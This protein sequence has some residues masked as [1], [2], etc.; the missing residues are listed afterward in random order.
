M[1]R[2]ARI[3]IRFLLVWALEALSL[4]VMTRIVP[5]IGWLTRDA[6]SAFANALTAALILALVNTLVRPLLLR[7]KLPITWLTSNGSTLVVNVLLLILIG[8]LLPLLD[9]ESLT[10][11]FLGGLVLSI[12]NGVLTGF[13]NI[14]RDDSFFQNVVEHIAKRQ[15][16][17]GVSEPGRGIVMLEIDGLSCR[18]LQA[19]VE[20]G[21]MP[22]VR[23]MLRTTHA[24]SGYD[25]G[26]PSQTSSSQAGILYGDNF[27]IPAFRWYDKERGKLMVSN[28]FDDAAEI[29]ARYAHGQGLLRGGSSINNLIAGDAEKSLLTLSTL[30]TANEQE[31]SRRAQDLYVFWLNPYLFTRSLVLS[32]GEVLLELGQAL[33]QRLRDVQPRINRLE[34]GY[35]F[36][37]ALT[38]VFLRDIST[39]LVALDVVRGV[40]AIY[41]TYLGYDVVAHHAGPDTSDALNTLRSLDRQVRRIRNVIAA[42]APR[43]YDLFV[44]SDHGQSLGATFRQ[45]YGQS[46]TELI[47]AHTASPVSVAEATGQMIG[48]SY[49]AA[50]VAEL[51]SAEQAVAGRMR[52]SAMRGSRRVLQQRIKN[53][54][55]AVMGAPVVVCA[56]GNLANV[57]FNLHSGKVSLSEINTEHPQLVDEL[58]MQAGIGFV[59]VY[60]DESTPLVL[61]KAG[62]RDLVTGIVTGVDP[63]QPYAR[64]D[65]RAQQLWRVAQFPHAGDLIIVSTLYHDEQVAAFEELVGSHGGLGGE[66]T[67]AFLLHPADVHMPDTNNSTDVFPVLN[68]RRGQL[69]EPAL[70]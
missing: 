9:I 64:P 46:L 4:V 54:Q 39:Y 15:L 33:R 20:G 12:V 68:A 23:D 58:V 56:S 31:R 53:E 61:G 1:D 27:D 7:L 47:A 57:Y 42:K 25:C 17:S 8:R 44:L 29:N 11:A 14:G 63:L 19:A 55:P 34:R 5:G 43:P 49:A 6:W 38:N 36:L 69:D 28:N 35:P 51:Q 62:A 70:R 45:R 32:L 41:T 26:L 50:L 37:R 10:A 21:L 67:T 48:M 3:S 22:T 24:V 52:R 65:L 60:N 59:I 2:A 13:V 16:M 30:N 66:Q 18:R 40:P